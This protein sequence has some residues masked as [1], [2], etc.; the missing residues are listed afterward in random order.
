MRVS[1]TENP[2]MIDR[3]VAVTTHPPSSVHDVTGS[4][5]LASSPSTTI[6]MPTSEGVSFVTS[7]A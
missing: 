6:A 4:P 2:R 7:M 3:P 1:E 5:V